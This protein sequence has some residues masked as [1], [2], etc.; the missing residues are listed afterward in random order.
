MDLEVVLFQGFDELDALGPLEVLRNASRAGVDLQVRL[1]SVDG[2]GV[3]GSHGVSVWVDRVLSH[4]ADLL[5][6]PGGGWN[7]RSPVGVRAEVKKGAIPKALAA[8]NQQGSFANSSLR[9]GRSASRRNPQWNSRAVQ[10][11]GH[12][13]RTGADGMLTSPTR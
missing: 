4:H 13:R 12:Q 11:R 1:V 6:V 8:A 3:T 2:R 5:V 9:L 10:L 7:D